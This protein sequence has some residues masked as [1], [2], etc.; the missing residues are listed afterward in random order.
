MCPGGSLGAVFGA[1]SPRVQAALH[2]FARVHLDL[3]E[4][5]VREGV[6]RGQFEV[7]DQRPRDVATQI[8]ASVQGALLMARI[9]SDP[10]VLDEVIPGLRR[11][12]GNVHQDT[13]RSS[14]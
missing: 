11:Y 13:P 1:V 8:A 14:R 3:L 2:R 7:G 9:T 6:D 5:I 4:G 10:H 12:L